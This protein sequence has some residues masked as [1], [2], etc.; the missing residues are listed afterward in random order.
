MLDG[1]VTIRRSRPRAVIAARVFSMRWAYSARSKLNVRFGMSAILH[2][3]RSPADLP[4]P[5]RRHPFE[6]EP[7]DGARRVPRRHHQDE[8]DPHV[9]NPQHLRLVDAPPLLEPAEDLAHR[10]GAALDHRPA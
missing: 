10:P 4:D 7:G 3:A 5:E 8:P 9:E 6:P 2:A 1:S